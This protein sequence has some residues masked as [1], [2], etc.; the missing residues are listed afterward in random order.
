MDNVQHALYVAVHV[1]YQHVVVMSDQLARASHAPGP[2]EMW[3]IHQQ[4]DF[5]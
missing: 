5:L 1:I 3:M 4:R 2:A